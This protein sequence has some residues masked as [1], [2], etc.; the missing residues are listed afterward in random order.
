MTVH[1]LYGRTVASDFPLHLAE[2]EGEPLVEQRYRLSTLAEQPDAPADGE[3]L[4]D[5][6]ERG[7]RWYAVSRQA[8]EGLLFR[9]FR[10]ADIRISPDWSDVEFAMLEGV[11]PAM[12]AVFGTGAVPALLL[13][14]G[15]RPVL[16]ASAVTSPEGLTVAFLGR[17]GQGKSTLATLLCLAGGEL[18]TDDVLPV[19]GRAPV[20]VAAGSTE[21]RLRQQAHEMIS[22]GDVSQRISADARKVVALR[23]AT[24][25]P[26]PRR[27]DAVFVP[28]PNRE[29]VLDILR[30]SRRQAHFT[31]LRYPRL[32]GW[33]SSDAIRAHFE[34]ASAIAEQVPVFLA[35][36]PWGPPFR[37][38]IASALWSAARVPDAVPEFADIDQPPSTPST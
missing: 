15:G 17:S 10:Q 28:L 38:D 36:V 25:D 20:T 7:Q 19:V 32:L 35:R 31:V 11:D 16:H 24:A 8:D 21:V 14:L 22:A 23:S 4:L 34:L 3:V 2:C 6:E 12:A 5:Y 13:C 27:L 18:L 26:E 9:I 30:I 1:R 33:R 29:G 37:D